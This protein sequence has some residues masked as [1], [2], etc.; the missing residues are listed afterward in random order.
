MKQTSKLALGGILSALATLCLL[1]TVFPY[2]TF[3]LPALAG[4]VLLPVSLECGSR[5]GWCCYAAV[6]LLAFFVA[7]D[8]ESALLFVLLFGYY[9]TLKLWLD[10]LL[11]P[12]LRWGLKLA[13]LNA[14]AIGSYFLATLVLHLPVEMELFGLD[15]PL[16]F[17]LLCN[18]VFLLYDQG[19]S[20]MVLVYETRLHPLISRIWR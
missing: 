6:S 20:N 11:N 7:P 19:L 15:L 8:K 16:V 14:T 13:L 1:L 17:L 3:A 9:P 5:W 10:S 4:L 18:G 12:I 2:A